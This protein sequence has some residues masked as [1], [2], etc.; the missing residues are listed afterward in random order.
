[1]IK[2]AL[3]HIH[4]NIQHNV[5]NVFV[6]LDRLFHWLGHG[7]QCHYMFFL[8]MP[9]VMYIS[10]VNKILYELSPQAKNLDVT[11]DYWLVVSNTPSDADT[12]NIHHVCG[13]HILKFT[14]SLEC[15][16]CKCLHHI[17]YMLD[18][19]PSF[20]SIVKLKF[21]NSLL[22]M[23][24]ASGE[25]QVSC[26]TLAEQHHLPFNLIQQLTDIIHQPIVL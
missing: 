21:P 25:N 16:Q 10:T 11:L 2:Q 1:M 14:Y 22:Y 13:L 26:G 8:D 23:P 5:Q 18:L 9:R 12:W 7:P 20:G 3:N 24:R 4:N 6:E 15:T 19:E 17:C